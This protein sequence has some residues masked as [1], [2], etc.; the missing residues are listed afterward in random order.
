MRKV[1]VCV[2][3]EEENGKNAPCDPLKQLGA[4]SS[5][6]SGP[7]SPGIFGRLPVAGR[8]VQKSTQGASAC[9]L[10]RVNDAEQTAGAAR[11]S[12]G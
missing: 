5:S 10:R 11:V 9:V 8:P 7:R 1:R 12:T 2:Y 6:Q 3:V 4:A